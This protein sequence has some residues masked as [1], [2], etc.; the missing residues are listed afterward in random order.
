MKTYTSQSLR[1]MYLNFFK[2]RG[3]K[4]I[5]SASLIP[6]NDPTVLFTT[7]GMHPLVP[8][9]LGEKHPAGNR[10]TDVQ[11]CV[12]TGDIDDVG[13]ERHCTFFEMLGNWSLGD[14]FKKE[15]IPWSYEFLTGENYLGIPSDKL[16]VTVFGGDESIPRDD[17]AAAL[18]E[19]AGIKKENIYYMPRENNW[20]GPA[21]L[22]GPCGTD[23]EMFVIR[24]PK[25]S[26]E[27][28]PDC[29]CGA[30]LEIW[31]DVFMRFN[32][33]ADGNFEE[34]S[35]KNVDTGMGLER[36]LCVLSGKS[37]VY[38]T[39][40]FE[41]A[42]KE[43]T[44]L[45]GKTYG[46]SEEITRA[47]RVLLDHTRTAT[48]M[49]GDEKGI[50]PSNTDQGYI[51]RRIIRRA[52]RFGRKIDLPEGSLAKISATFIEQYKT[53]YPELQ[54][55]AE[56]IADELN[57]EEAKF[58]KTLQ[59]GL[60]EFE[61]CIGGLERKNAFMK[62]KDPAY[63]PETVIAGKAAFRLY[64]TYGFPVE[65]TAE[66]AKERGFGV[67]M[68]G[69]NAAFEEHQSKSK[70]GSEQKF[71]CGLADH[72]E[73]TT[74]LHTATHLL[75][76][77]LKKVCSPDVNQKG[78][79]ITE[80]RLRFDFNYPQPLTAEQIKAVEDLVNEKIREDIPVVMQELSIE[81]AKAQGF[82]GLFESKYG[83]RVKT[84][85]IGDF[86]KEICGGPHAETTGKLGKF[87][88][89]K[90]QSSSAGIRRIKAV[91]IHE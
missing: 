45:T 32:K 90:E 70:A 59:Q 14:Y 55:N 72:K 22:T 15:M 87:K 25:C 10:L 26:P 73:E 88:I 85:T 68:D 13:D 28:N 64:D 31:N 48:F 67:D 91:L 69:Y 42:I 74:N 89:Q 41:N 1:E 6:E 40:I 35:Q 86:S 57:K 33:T 66:M 5:P 62:E 56:K 20:W 76:A 44:A 49:I 61:K 63:V 47:F 19:N 11:K 52:V 43:I 3:H 27:C 17:E 29:N 23:T 54:I 82:T 12:R 77:A 9:L 2:E 53:V 37:S 46:E 75:H 34:L 60:K 36:A 4:V 8:Y 78:S 50:V 21:G 83:E 30:F 18:W 7:A 16:A 80:E 38:E 65:I 84:Y 39:D 81:E 58:S 71:A 51:L 24:K 79:N